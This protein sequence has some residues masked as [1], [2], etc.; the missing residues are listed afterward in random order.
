ML[1][2]QAAPW[3]WSWRQSL[4][5]LELL[6]SWWTRF[7]MLHQRYGYGLPMVSRGLQRRCWKTTL[8]MRTQRI[9]SKPPWL[10]LWSPP[11]GPRRRFFV[12]SSVAQL[13]FPVKLLF[14][15]R[16]PDRQVDLDQ[17]H[18]RRGSPSPA[19]FSRPQQ[20]GTRRP[21]SSF[22]DRATTS[23]T[24]RALPLHSAPPSL[25]PPPLP[26]LPATALP[27]YQPSY[28]CCPPCAP[29]RTPIHL[30]SGCCSFLCGCRSRLE[31]P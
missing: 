27:R 18:L 6:C 4:T 21:R 5:V 25:S 2:V 24:G 19:R 29:R 30:P 31:C 20:R 10:P 14:V 9:P 12:A 13:K 3:C 22:R 23:A 8:V 28:C 26:R 17:Q 11:G 7:L 15:H 16:A 1:I